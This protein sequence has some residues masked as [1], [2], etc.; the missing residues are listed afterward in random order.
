MEKV[1]V[2]VGGIGSQPS[3]KD[4][5][6]GFYRESRSVR[7][8]GVSRD[9]KPKG[10][11]VSAYSLQV[12]LDPGS[13]SARQTQFLLHFLASSPPPVPFSGM[14]SLPGGR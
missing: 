9:I 12:G 8:L 14:L 10:E 11:V 3:S 13:R 5:E 4:Q 6:Q 2:G 1:H 7:V